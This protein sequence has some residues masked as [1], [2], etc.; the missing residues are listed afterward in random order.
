M[1][2]TARRQQETD[3]PKHIKLRPVVHVIVLCWEWR[4]VTLLNYYDAIVLIMR[5]S[6]GWS[7]PQLYLHKLSLVKITSVTFSDR[8]TLRGSERVGGGWAAA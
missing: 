6:V 8:N 4:D 3:F 2:T 1:L 5:S 7:C